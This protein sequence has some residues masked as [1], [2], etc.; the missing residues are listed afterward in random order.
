MNIEQRVA[1]LE[2]Q[3][4]W[5]KRGGGLALAAVACVVLMGQGRKPKEL[6][7]LE[8]SSITVKDKAGRTRARLGVLAG[9]SCVLR[10]NDKAGQTRA[11]L[12]VLADGRP[13]LGLGDKAGRAR[14]YLSVAGGAQLTMYGSNGKVIWQAPK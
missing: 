5:M 6:A 2:R 14:I 7:D 3:N 12:G 4:R 9:G 10:L 8:V 1:K 13:T 11:S